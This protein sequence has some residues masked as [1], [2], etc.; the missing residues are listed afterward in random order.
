MVNIRRKCIPLGKEVLVRRRIDLND[1][2]RCSGKK[3]FVKQNDKTYYLTKPTLIDGF[4]RKAL[5]NSWSIR[6]YI[7]EFIIVVS[8]I[9]ILKTWIIFV[10]KKLF[11]D[12][13]LTQSL[14]KFNSDELYRYKDW[15]RKIKRLTAC[16]KLKNYDG[17][18]ENLD[19]CLVVVSLKYEGKPAMLSNLFLYCKWNWSYFELF[20]KSKSFQK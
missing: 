15:Y 3:K 11:S 1:N 13:K 18:L 14:P 8:L 2:K 19:E 12:G 20:S 9:K 5:K 17:A 7:G 16:I 10:L 6:T 4:K